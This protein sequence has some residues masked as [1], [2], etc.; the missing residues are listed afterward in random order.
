MIS[1][2]I[3]TYNRAEYLQLAISSV[4]NQSFRDFEIIVV[5]DASTDNTAKVAQ[6]YG[7]KIKYIRHKDNLERGVARNTG[8]KNAS[9]D[10]VA[11]LDSDDMWE[12][13]HLEVCLNA[14]KYFPAAGVAYSGSYLI[15]S[16]GFILGKLVFNPSHGY[17]LRKMVAN[18][19]FGG[20]NASSCLVKKEIF[21]QSGYFNEDRKLSGSEDWEMWARLAAITQ[22]ISSNKYTAKVRFHEG[23]SS[24]NAEKM[25][26]SMQLALNLIYQNSAIGPNLASV[27]NKA[28]SSLYCAIAINFYSA[29]K[30]RIS[31]TYIYNSLKTYPLILVS[32]KSFF[33]TFI[34]TFL[35]A[36]LTL[37]LKRLKWRFRRI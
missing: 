4:L 36:R 3:P 32:N 30:M 22:F 27:K 17:V 26:K 2:I 34:R 19:S 10:M 31:R 16:R 20:C 33:Y 13:R 28:F 35:G 12:S 6:V 8:I 29:G 7:N 24:I 18:Y 5:D 37:F 15:D 1:V 14:F 9:G 25:A 23:K 11:F 21:K